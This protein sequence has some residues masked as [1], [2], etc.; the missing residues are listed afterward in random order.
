MADKLG[1]A[2]L[3]MR[4]VLIRFVMADE[5]RFDVM[6][7]YGFWRVAMGCG[8]LDQMRSVMTCCDAIRPAL[9]WQIR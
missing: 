3:A 9:I 7:C 5:I 2:G 1:S 8:R 4:F 6:R